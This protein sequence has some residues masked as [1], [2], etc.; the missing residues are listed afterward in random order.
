MESS[1]LTSLFC[2]N[3]WISLFKATTVLEARREGF[4]VSWK[5]PSVRVNLGP[6]GAEV[7]EGGLAYG[8][9]VP[10]LTKDVRRSVLD[11]GWGTGLLTR[12]LAARCAFVLAIDPSRSDDRRLPQKEIG[13]CSASW[14]QPSPRSTR[15][16]RRRYILERLRL[17]ARGRAEE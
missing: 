12:R 4:V 11:I 9:V 2:L 16:P 5:M 15:P 8:G 6:R 10:L 17:C 1:F 14:T 7:L 13:E 3:F